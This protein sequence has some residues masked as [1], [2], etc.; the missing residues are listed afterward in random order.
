[1]AHDQ[2]YELL[3][4]RKNINPCDTSWGPLYLNRLKISKKKWKD[5]QELKPFLPQDVHYFYDM[6][7][8]EDEDSKIGNSVQKEIQE[9]GEVKRKIRNGKKKGN[10]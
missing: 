1:M 9:K 8:Y 10:K 6:I 5:L 2:I 7:P 4:Q 3:P